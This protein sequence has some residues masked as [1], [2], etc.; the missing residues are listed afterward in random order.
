VELMLRSTFRAHSSNKKTPSSL[1][2][3]LGVLVLASSC[4][5]WFS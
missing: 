1:L 2:Q 4:F 3:P 5:A